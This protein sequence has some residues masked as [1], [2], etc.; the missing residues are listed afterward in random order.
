MVWGA[1]GIARVIINEIDEHFTH[2]CYIEQWNEI[3]KKQ[4]GDAYDYTDKVF[5]GSA[6]GNAKNC[7]QSGQVASC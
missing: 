4:H 6:V 1:G 5:E 3:D 7:G 2:R